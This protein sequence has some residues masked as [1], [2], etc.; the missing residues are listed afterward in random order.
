MTLLENVSKATIRL[1]LEEPFWGHVLV[2]LRKAESETT[3]SLCWSL[4]SDRNIQLHINAAFWD[5]LDPDL[6]Y[7]VMKHEVLH[8]VLRH[9]YE[10]DDF[11]HA[12]L[13]DI[14]ADLVVNQYIDESRRM[15]D[16]ICIEKFTELDLERNMD[17]AYYY[18]KLSDFIQDEESQGG[19][20]DGEGETQDGEGQTQEQDDEGTAQAQAGA[21]RARLEELLEGEGHHA[22]WSELSGLSEAEKRLHRDEMRPV[23][24]NS[25]EQHWGEVPAELRLEIQKLVTRPQNFRW[26]RV[27]RVFSQSSK[28][29]KIK[30]TISR[31]SK[32]YGTTPGIKVQRLHKVLVAIDTSASVLPAEVAMFFSEVHHLYRTGSEIYVVECDSKIGDHYP[33]KGTAPTVVSG[34]GGTDF[35]PPV[36]FA[37]DTYRPDCLLYFT[38]GFG[39]LTVK[40]RCP[41]L[42]VITSGGVSPDEFPLPGRKLWLPAVPGA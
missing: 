41:I 40:S 26:Q 24:A 10:R 22:G 15:P 31:P 7:G 38:D 36:V 37:N 4:A 27:L 18:R 14:A 9:P 33:Y 20:Q 34:G 39:P 13:Y 16:A 11:G 12:R 5:Q 23:T 3:E 35:T 8:L 19:Q 17:V 29:T 42:W 28:R 30:T 6:R 21:D 1:I 2:G 25:Y 32:R